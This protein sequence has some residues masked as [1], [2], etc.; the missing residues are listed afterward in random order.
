MDPVSGVGISSALRLSI[1]STNSFSFVDP[2][3][4]DRRLMDPRSPRDPGDGRGAGTVLGELIEC[5]GQHGAADVF[6]AAMR[7]GRAHRPSLSQVHLQYG[8]DSVH[9]LSQ[10]NLR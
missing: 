8:R 7:Y 4:V 9:D 6:T 10:V 2:S 3:P 1:A 5:R